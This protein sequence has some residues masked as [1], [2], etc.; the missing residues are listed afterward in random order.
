MGTKLFLLVEK[1]KTGE[2]KVRSQVGPVLIG[3]L[4]E[5]YTIHPPEGG[6]RT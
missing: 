1:A 3:H 6:A 4:E 5:M 2:V